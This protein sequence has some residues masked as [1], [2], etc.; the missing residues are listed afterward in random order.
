VTVREI[1]SLIEVTLDELG[2]PW[3]RRLLDELVRREGLAR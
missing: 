3:C 2:W 1:R